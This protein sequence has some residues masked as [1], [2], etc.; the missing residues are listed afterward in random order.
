VTGRDAQGRKQYRYRPGQELFQY[1]DEQGTVRDIGSADVNAYLREISGRDF[2]AE[3]FRTWA[4]TALAAE[5]LQE[6]EDF[7]SEAAAK[8]NV[9][10]AMPS[11]NVK[12]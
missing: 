10:Q 6:F 9:T 3:D 8:R 11:T 5:A 12:S 1:V 2:T 7:D 4:G